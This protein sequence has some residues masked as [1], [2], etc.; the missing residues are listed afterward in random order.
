MVVDGQTLINK[1]GPTKCLTLGN[2][3]DI[4]QKDIREF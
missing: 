3:S 2:Y 4:S 1:I